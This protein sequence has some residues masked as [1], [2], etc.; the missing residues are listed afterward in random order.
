LTKRKSK[1]K[2]WKLKISP[3]TEI[4]GGLYERTERAGPEGQRSLQDLL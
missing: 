3:R 1:G 4:S 2:A